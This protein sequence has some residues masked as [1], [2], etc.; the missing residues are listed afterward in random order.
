MLTKFPL[1]N[2]TILQG[3]VFCLKL[4]LYSHSY[5]S[6]KKPQITLTYSNGCKLLFQPMGQPPCTQSI[7]LAVQYWPEI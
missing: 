4:E 2:L 3:T 1:L 5:S 7:C 6:R